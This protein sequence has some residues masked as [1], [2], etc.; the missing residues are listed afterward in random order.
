MLLDVAVKGKNL[1]RQ[2]SFLTQQQP[3]TKKIKLR[4]TFKMDTPPSSHV[5]HK[6]Q[7]LLHDGSTSTSATPGDPLQ[8]LAI[9]ECP[10]SSERFSECLDLKATQKTSSWWTVPRYHRRRS[11]SPP[12]K[13]LLSQRPKHL[14]AKRPRSNQTFSRTKPQ[15]HHPKE[16]VAGPQKSVPSTT[17]S[18]PSTRNYRHLHP[19]SRRLLKQKQHTSIKDLLCTCLTRI[20]KTFLRIRGVLR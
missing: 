17:N 19:R 15:R 18:V 13:S 9:Y 4:H 12:P 16:S 2:R 5:N 7:R 3:R 8:A 14:L 11:Q 1:R 10:V 20:G 6:S